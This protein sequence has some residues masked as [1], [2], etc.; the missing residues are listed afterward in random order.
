MYACTTHKKI[1]QGD[2]P[3]NTWSDW[4]DNTTLAAHATSHENGGSDEISVAGLSGTLA[5][6]QTPTAHAASHQSGGGDA[7][8]LDDLATPDD[9]TD[10][11]ATTGHHGLLPKLPGGTTDFLRAD[12]SFASPGT[13]YTDEQAQDAVGAMV[14]DSSNV[15]L[16]YT[17]ATPALVADLTDTAVTPGSYTSANIT[18]DAKGRVTAAANGTGGGGGGGGLTMLEE[19]V[20]SAS[21]SLVFTTFYS[22]D[23]ETYV[24]EISDLITAS[25]TQVGIQVS[26]DG[27]STWL[28]GTDYEF[29]S[30]YH[31][32]GG[33][34]GLGSGGTNRFSLREGAN[35]TLLANCGYTATLR[36][37][38]LASAL[39]KAFF[40]EHTVPD[41]SA[42]L[43]VLR[44]GG[45]IKTTSA[46]NAIR[47]IADSGNLTSGVAR[48]YGLP[49]A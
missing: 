28:A 11:D 12:G 40:A 23:Y 37:Q 20:A 48:V 36:F 34:G 35:T 8:K 13:S 9:N 7:I 10:L 41:S 2:G 14:D 33:T 25:N 30:F 45:R 27:G 44:S 16:T 39:H 15:T 26:T 29:Y 22:T 5:D 38:S 32:T 1:Y 24:L 43:I 31:Y 3:G 6:P 18:V 46:I 47:I 4:H 21:A 42:N 19:H 49:K 17:D